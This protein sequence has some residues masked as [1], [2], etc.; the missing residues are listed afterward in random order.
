MN[1]NLN[2]RFSLVPDINI[3]RSRFERNC[4][5]KTS[6]DIGQV[7]PFFVDE[8][9]PG[10]SFQLKTNLLARMQ[11]MVSAPLDDLWLDTYYFF[12]PNRLVWEHW[13]EFNGENTESAWYPSVEYSVPLLSSGDTGFE[14]GSIA[15]YMGLPVGVAGLE[16]NALPFRSYALICNEWFR[17]ENLVAPLQI[18]V[19]DSTYT[20]TKLASP[21]N[22]AQYAN[23]GKPFIAAK[24]HD[25]FSSCLPSPQKGSDV[26]LNFSHGNIP[27]ITEANK[28]T[29]WDTPQPALSFLASSNGRAPVGND[30]LGYNFLTC[31]SSGNLSMSTS[32]DNGV[33]P[34]NLA[35]D[36]EG[37]GFTINSL[38]TAVAIQQ[39]Y[40]KDAR[41]GSRYT[42][43]LKG[44][45]GVTSPDA[46]LQ[47]P[48]YLGGN[49]IPVSVNQVVQQSSSVENS[50]Q[51]NVTGLSLT[52]DSHGDFMQSF[53]EHGF[54]I[55]VCVARYAHTYQQ[56]IE[57]MWSRKGRFDYYWPALANI[58]EMAVLNKEI[59][60]QG[61]SI[62]DEVFGYQEAWADYRYKPSRV[63]GEMRSNH[64]KTLDS[65]HFADD[66]DAL[67]HLSS[68]WIQEDKANVDRVM[69]ITSSVSNQMFVDFYIENT[70]TRPM[71]LYSVPGLE[72]I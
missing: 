51:G 46:R 34:C 30:P 69:A 68:A 13:K 31:N 38:R 8:V 36:T 11:P 16:V 18:P 50:P 39:L 17:D 64:T 56:G 37:L 23:G 49:R 1:R 48:E 67:P 41:T 45:F 54:I 12:V 25:Y 24:A 44:H 29:N 4:S 35:V 27:I 3:Q 65:W 43:I 58:G 28:Q 60:A 21:Y 61:K 57:R 7:V 40:E 6:F 55:G 10:D 9:L 42:E 47:R 15:D 59:Y 2:E 62:D 22:P 14:I 63:T 66:Y 32:Q 52:A 53:T 20:Y 26:L 72:R 70:T 5:I 33:F 71:P 19:D